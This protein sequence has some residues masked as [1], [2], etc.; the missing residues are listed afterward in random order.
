MP[1]NKLISFTA[2]IIL[3]ASLLISLISCQTN[4]TITINKVNQTKNNLNITYSFDN[5]NFI[6][7]YISIFIWITNENR[8]EIKNLTDNFSI[9]RDPPIERE[10]SFTIPNS[11]IK[12][13]KKSSQTIYINIAPSINLNNPTKQQ[14]IIQKQEKK[15]LS[16]NKTLIYLISFIIIIFILINISKRKLHLNQSKEKFKNK[17]LL[18]KKINS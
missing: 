1:R 11:I 9:N 18:P 3:F 6:G 14:F 10:I 7:N 15:P 12:L 13:S 16:V 5:S 2:L 4:Q 8:T 17:G